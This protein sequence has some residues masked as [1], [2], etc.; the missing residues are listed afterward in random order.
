MLNRKNGEVA[1]FLS[2]LIFKW[3]YRKPEF[4]LLT[5]VPRWKWFVWLV[6]GDQLNMAVQCIFGTLLKVTCATVNMYTRQNHLF[7][8]TRKKLSCLNGHPVCIQVYDL[9]SFNG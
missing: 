3:K 4:D 9:P 7:Q 2:F 5:L 6:Q 1:V 8:G